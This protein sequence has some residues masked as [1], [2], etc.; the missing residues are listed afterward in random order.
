MAVVPG[1]TSLSASQG[2]HNFPPLEP[3]GAYSWVVF[4]PTMIKV[5]KIANKD[6][7]LGFVCDFDAGY[8]ISRPRWYFLKD[9]KKKS[10]FSVPGLKV[11]AGWGSPLDIV[12]GSCL[13]EYCEAVWS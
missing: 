10:I 13:C 4:T 12:L 5:L 9:K 3:R 11:S 8:P 7:Q 1:V 2:V 6:E